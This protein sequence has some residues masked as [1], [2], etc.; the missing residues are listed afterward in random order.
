MLEASVRRNPHRDEF[1][2]ART[3]HEGGRVLL[4]PLSGQE[5]HMVVQAGHADALVAVGLGE[6]ELERGSEA[7][8]LPL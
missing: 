2:R 3:R 5:S 4:T 8:Y 7:P 6:G 1:V